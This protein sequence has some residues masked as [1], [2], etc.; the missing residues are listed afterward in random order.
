MYNINKKMTKSK[1]YLQFPENNDSFY[2]QRNVL[3]QTR[4]YSENK[5]KVLEYKKK[6]YLFKKQAEIFRHILLD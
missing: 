6:R 4:F 1:F 3:Y 5:E 2:K